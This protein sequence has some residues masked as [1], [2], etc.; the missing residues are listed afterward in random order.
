MTA[1]PHIHELS[2][3]S[4]EVGTIGVW[5]DGMITRIAYNETDGLHPEWVS[6]CACFIASETVSK[7]GTTEFVFVGIGA[8]DKRPVKFTMLA[9]DCVNTQ[10]FRGQLANAFGAQNLIGTIT[11]AMVQKMSVDTIVKERVEIPYWKGNIPMVPGVDLV[12]DV[13]FDLSSS[14]PVMVYDGDINDAIDQIERMLKF[15]PYAP[16]VVCAVFAAPAIARW[17]PARRFFL[18]IWGT[19]GSFKTSFVLMCIAIYGIVFGEEPLLKANK[20]GS[21]AVGAQETFS[22]CGFL[23]VLY[24]NV[25][26][27]NPKDSGNYIGAMQMVC[28]GAIKAR[29]K[30]E[31]GLKDAKTFAC[32]PIVTGEIRPEEAST[33][34]RGLNLWWTKKD[35]DKSVLTEIQTHKDILP[36]I[37][38]HWLRFLSGT[39][40]T[41]CPDFDAVRSLKEKEL[42]ELK[43][44]NAGR[45]ATISTLLLGTW[46]LLE[47]SPFGDVFKK[48]RTQFEKALADVIRANAASVTDESESAKFIRGVKQVIASNPKCIQGRAPE[49]LLDQSA[50]EVPVGGRRVLPKPIGKWMPEGIFLMPD[51]T[52]KA[53]AT[54]KLFAQMPTEPSLNQTLNQKGWLITPRDKNPNSPDNHLQV[55]QKI[56]GIN[57]RGWYIKTSA[58]VNTE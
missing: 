40:L 36:T 4:D 16:L 17:H 30:K 55:Q 24:D 50:L 38:Y 11:F 20:D 58:L 44:D 48:F 34:A 22:L 52:L 31:G 1:E 26:A 3:D 41:L 28:E 6:D 14:V 43:F 5:Q 10:K 27:V 49:Q 12:E 54:M 53:V 25:K 23:A 18:A 46:D 29:G 15:H 8:K 57:G 56:N 2:F 39:D 47:A 9:T 45:P 13:E 51:P 7:D 37:G 21:T 32:T 42:A 33:T 19:T 35:A